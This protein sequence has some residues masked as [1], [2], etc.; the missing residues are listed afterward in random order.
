MIRFLLISP[1]ALL[2]ANA[3]YW[4]GGLGG[5]KIRRLVSLWDLQAERLDKTLLEEE[6]IRLRQSPLRV[7]DVM[8]KPAIT[9][10]VDDSVGAAVMLM[11]KAGIKRLPVVDENG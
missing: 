1:S 8:S 10:R 4:L 6:L 9:V 11:A 2:G 5:R 7:A 3:R